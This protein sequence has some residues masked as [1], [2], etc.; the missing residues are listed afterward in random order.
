MVQRQAAVEDQMPKTS[1]LPKRIDA[2]EIRNLT[3][4]EI[5]V[6]T[7]GTKIEFQYTKQKPDGSGGGSSS[8]SAGAAAGS[9]ALF[10]W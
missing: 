8:S 1:N 7:G 4:D 3:L 10:G 9:L 2:P 6:V 5:N